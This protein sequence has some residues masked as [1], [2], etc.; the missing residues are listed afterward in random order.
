MRAGDRIV[1]FNGRQVDSWSQL[2]EFIRGNGDGEA[3]LG[4]ER[5]GVSVSLTPTHTLLTEV[6]DLNNPG[7]TVEA[8]YLGVSPTMVV[9]HSGPGDTVSQMWTMSKQSLSALARLPVLTWNVASD[10]VT[11]QAL[12][13]IHI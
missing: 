2:Q 6:P 11:G 3:R 12:S 7:R 9:V 8:G 10:L 4:V 5:N 13:L 1:S